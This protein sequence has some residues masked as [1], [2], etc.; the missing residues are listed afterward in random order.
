LDGTQYIKGKN[1]VS[2]STGS[3]G[4]ITIQLSEGATDV[5]I[6]NL[7][8]YAETGLTG[9]QVAFDQTTFSVADY[10]DNNIKFYLNGQL[11]ISGSQ[12]SVANN[13]SDYYVNISNETIDFNTEIFETDVL[14]IVYHND[15]TDQRGQFKYDRILSSDQ[16]AGS[17][18]W[19]NF[20]F[21]T[22]D[23]DYDKFEVFINGQLLSR[24][25][26][27]PPNTVQPYEI[28]AFNRLTFDVDLYAEDI[29]TLLF[30]IPNPSSSTDDTTEEDQVN[31]KIKESVRINTEYEALQNVPFNS[32]SFSLNEYTKDYLLLYLNGKLLYSGSE[33]QTRRSVAIADYYVVDDTNIIFSDKIFPDDIITFDL[34]IPGYDDAYNNTT[35]ITSNKSQLNNTLQL[36]S[37]N[38]IVIEKTTENIIIKNDKI[39]VFN[40]LLSGI[41]DGINTNF[42]L[43]SDPFDS[44]QISIFVN[45]MLNI[46]DG[47]ADYYDYQV[48]GRTINFSPSSTPPSGSIVMAIYNKA[49]E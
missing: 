21:T 39:L 22:I 42:S 5:G 33:S 48:S 10:N 26:E 47:I 11:L 38:G 31:Y 15:T 2:V 45:G 1:G 49:E 8:M 6:A 19:F 7:E 18:V 14:T 16:P 20:D 24:L 35:F 30:K 27:L 37:S 3:N 43:L 28:S 44:T 34:M 13:E 25:D 41:P 23:N 9:T 46:P 12:S 29:I 36:S 32:L 40:E 4:S 17:R